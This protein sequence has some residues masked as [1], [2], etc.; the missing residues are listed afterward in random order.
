MKIMRIGS[1][2]VLLSLLL[3][4]CGS[5][6]HRRS[7]SSVIPPNEDYAPT[8]DEIPSDIAQIPDAVPQEEPLSR[9]GNP[10]TYTVFGENYRVLDSATG[11]RQRGYASWYGKK[12]HGRKTASGER[13]N[14]Y[15]MT[16]AH[17]NL[18]LPTY[19]RV[20]HLGN[21]KTTVVKVNDR[22]PFHSDRIIDLSYAAA[23][24]LDIIGHGTAMVEIEA[25][26]SGDE[27]PTRAPAAPQNI[28]M[29]PLARSGYLQVAA[30]SDPINAIALREELQAHGIGPVEIRIADEQD[31]AVH[32]VVV[33]PFKNEATAEE[34]LKQLSARSL[35]A[36]WTDE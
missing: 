2:L 33:G 30:Y 21:G 1:V 8:E 11:F 34:M 9:S 35:R 25:I 19:V 4:A 32:R 6:P 24:K 22:G 29:K 23:A 16:A 31:A 26:T 12:F 13:Y 3:S 27:T 28:E 36:Q 20:T 14:I 5:Q 17:K 18:P 10:K 7:G 15:G